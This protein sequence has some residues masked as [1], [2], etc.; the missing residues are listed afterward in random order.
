MTSPTPGIPSI[1]LQ[2]AFG[3]T[4]LGRVTG[5]D[6]TG[7]EVACAVRP[8]GH[9]L[10]VCHGKGGSFLQAAASA[11]SEAAELW[12]AEQVDPSALEWGCFEE[13]C[14]RYPGRVWPA[15]ALGS[16]GA[17][18]KS[19]LSG[20]R[21][22]LAWRVAEDLLG[23][24]RVRVPAQAVHCPPPGCPSLGPL[25]VSWS[26]NGMGAHPRREEALCHAL[27]EAAERDQLAQALPEGFTQEVL[28]ERMID[29]R[30]LVAEAPRAAA[31]ATRIAANGFEVFLLDLSPERQG[32]GRGRAT[33][34]AG[35][36]GL[37]LAGALLVDREGGPVP[38]TAGYACALEMEEALLGALWE[39]AQS[40]LTDIHG[41]R[42]DVEAAAP[43]EVARL[44]AVCE[45]VVPRRRVFRRARLRRGARVRA[46]LERLSVAGHEV[47]AVELS[48]EAS[49]LCVV[50]VLVPGFRVSELL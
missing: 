3:V 21:T 1:S 19:D 39:S 35:A 42:E 32:R 47:A 29:P 30:A 22:R 10:Q 45:A 33:A 34:E 50:K 13:M 11:V 36:L 20:P 5:L 4:R 9:V 24:G 49:G 27:L 8:L 28:E 31:E 18:E 25:G 17:V 46:V 40:R 26:S 48:P 43:G 15:W 37:P 16:A 14:E 6:R 12:A 44:R 2:R 7:V 41:A 23:G 38:L